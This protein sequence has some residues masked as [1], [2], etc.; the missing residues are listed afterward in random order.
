MS[1]YNFQTLS[2]GLTVNQE[3]L[4]SLDHPTALFLHV[5][6]QN[7]SDMNDGY[8]IHFKV[9]GFTIKLQVAQAGHERAS[10]S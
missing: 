6:R 4:F 3:R 9:A 2:H 7:L 10:L 8:D 5:Q 1:S